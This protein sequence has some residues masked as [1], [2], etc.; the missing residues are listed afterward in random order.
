MH[1]QHGVT[2]AEHVGLAQAR[3]RCRRRVQAAARLFAGQ[4]EN[5]QL[6]RG[7]GIADGHVHHETVQLG[8]RQGEGALLLDR[9]LRGHH[10]EQ[11]GQAPGT[12]SHG[13]L[14]LGHGFEQGRLHL[15][16]RAVDLICQHDVMEQRTALELE[17]ARLRPEN[18]RACEIGRQQI[19]GELHA[20]EIRL[21]ITGQRLDHGGLGQA[22]STLHQQMTVR[23]QRHQQAVN[24][25]RL[26]NDAASQVVANVQKSLLQAGYRL[27]LGHV[28]RG[29]RHDL[30]PSKTVGR[31]GSLIPVTL[32]KRFGGS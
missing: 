22:G 27:G 30:A 23:E 21:D 2:C 17:A 15:G 29:F 10:H 32:D 8:L 16:R 9:V 31:A 24:Q 4:L 11:F 13:D 7:I 20:V 19:G 18:V 3:A 28:H 25:M 14:S 12:A 6:R 26:A 1:G 5:G